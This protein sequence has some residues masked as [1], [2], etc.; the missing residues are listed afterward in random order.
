MPDGGVV[1]LRS[2][3]ERVGTVNPPDNGL[4]HNGGPSRG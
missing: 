3:D 2:Q 1:L 4:P